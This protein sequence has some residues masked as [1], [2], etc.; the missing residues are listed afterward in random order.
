MV[1]TPAKKVVDS[2]DYANKNF[3]IA[4]QVQACPQNQ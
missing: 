3:A 4:P 1:I 2:K